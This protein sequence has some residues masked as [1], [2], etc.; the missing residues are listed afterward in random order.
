MD[1][2]TITLIFAALT[3]LL[4][5]IGVVGSIFPRLPGLPLLWASIVIFAL[6]TRF[7]IVDIN[8]LLLVTMLVALEVL[9]DFAGSLRGTHKV[10][11]NFWGVVGAVA[12]VFIATGF[13]NIAL[14]IILPLSGVI[15]GQLI[16]GHDA[17][18]K[19]QMK[20]YTMIGYVGG[21]LIK[22]IIGVGIIALFFLRIMEVT[23]GHS[24]LS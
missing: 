13:R 17:L 7:D 3:V 20:N 8:F 1:Q 4:M 24:I 11:M 22:A 15:I 6:A 14:F 12:G 5:S 18:Y 9:L 19:V 21:T 10:Q 16:T 2:E 23:G